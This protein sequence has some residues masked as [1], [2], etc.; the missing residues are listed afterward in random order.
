MQACVAA[1]LY[2]DPPNYFFS[3]PV[4]MSRQAASIR[5]TERCHYTSEK[6]GKE[7]RCKNMTQK[8]LYC[9]IHEKLLK[10]LRITKSGIPRSGA[11]VYTTKDIPKGAKICQ[12]T[13]E[14]IVDDD[15]DYT[16]P[17]A[18]QIKE[19]PA[20]Y[21]DGA[22]TNT[23]G[24]GRWV[25]DGHGRLHNNAELVYDKD[26][27]KAWVVAL[28]R[29]KAGDE[30]LVDYGDTY[31]WKKG[32]H[33]TMETAAEQREQRKPK[34]A[35]IKPPEQPDDDSVPKILENYVPP[36]HPE[37]AKERKKPQQR[38]A[39]LRSR[40]T[41]QSKQERA[42]AKFEKEMLKRIGII[43]EL[44]QDKDLAQKIK[45]PVSNRKV[46]IPERGTDPV[47]WQ[48]AL[49]KAFKQ[50]L[51]DM[52]A[53]MNKNPRNAVDQKRAWDIVDHVYRS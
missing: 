51:K 7:V 4:Y 48:R 16:N 3:T 43:Q 2:L 12:Y 34:K 38:N 15:P 27:G 29:I 50:N 20:T 45:V 36:P 5:R 41:L 44:Y 46:K 49:E 8:G 25:N 24:E 1:L 33:G 10:G 42:D 22:M 13:G 31:P 35:L 26:T 11:G 39:G 53:W 40:P 37:P 28:K 14:E 23:P 30:I 6:N 47:Q 32:E 19:R 18:L 17:Y 52:A 9:W 21:I